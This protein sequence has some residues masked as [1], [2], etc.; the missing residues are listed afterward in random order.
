MK[1]PKFPNIKEPV[2]TFSKSHLSV[3]F[4]NLVQTPTRWLS[5]SI[6]MNK[7]VTEDP[8]RSM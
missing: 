5:V 2:L 1:H 7:V 6:N 8:G 4:N 3:G